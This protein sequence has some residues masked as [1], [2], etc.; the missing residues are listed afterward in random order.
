MC[1]NLKMKARKGITISEVLI[2]SL[3]LVTA[4]V[5]VL[6]A[7]TSAQTATIGLEYKTH[8]L[9]LARAKIEDIRA[10][11]IYDYGH[12][13]SAASLALD[14]SYLC[15][16]TDDAVTSDLRQITVS[17]GYD[18]NGDKVLGTEEI[19]V[20]LNTLVARR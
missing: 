2:A 1:H 9:M 3:L 12:S 5:P 19:R 4:T 16:V 13:Y 15:T 6:K 14:G 7:L 10:R 20:T 17:V 8:S 11:A 18:E